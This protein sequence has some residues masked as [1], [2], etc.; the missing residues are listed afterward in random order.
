MRARISSIAREN[1]RKKI[2]PYGSWKSPITSDMVA[3]GNIGLAQIE[4]KDKAIYW[5]EM[6]PSEK[7]RH[8]I[9]KHSNVGGTVDINPP[10]FNART[11]VHEYGGGSYKIV[12]NEV[13]FINFADQII[14]RMK[15]GENPN[16]I[17]FETALR[18]ADFEFD[19][20]R[21]RL[22]CIREDHREKGKE[23]TNTV[24]SM[25]LEG[26]KV[27]TLTQ[28]NDFYSSPR[29]SPN[30]KYLAFL[31]WNHP[32]MPWDK[33]EL[34]I[35][36]L[37]QD[38]SIA[39]QNR[40]NNNSTESIVQPVW[41]PDNILYFVSDRNNWWNI[42]CWKDDKVR[43]I[44]PKEA[45]FA[46][47]PWIFAQSN[48]DFW[49]ENKIICSF[50][51]KGRWHIARLDTET[52][53]LEV[54]ETPYTYI[55]SLRTEDDYAVFIGGSP[56]VAN[57]IVKMNLKTRETEVL[58]NSN[59]ITIDSDYLSP[60]QPIEF[61]TEKGLTAYAI[62]YKPKNKRY[63][64][65]LGTLPP[66]LVS[67][68]GGPTAAASKTFSLKIQF[69]TSRGFAVIEANYGGSTGYG[70]EY[71][72]RLHGQWGVVDVDDSVN[73]AKYLVELGEV[74]EEKLAI[75][76]GSAGGYTTLNSLT[77]RDI[78]KTGASYFGISDLET[79]VKDTHKFE[80]RYLEW[81][82]GC[83]PEKK[84]VY[85]QRS[86]I[87]FLE[88]LDAPMIVFQGLDDKIVPPNQAEL[89]VESLRKKGR[90]IVYL[91]FKDEQHGFR[92]AKN[93]KRSLE[94]ELFFYSRIFGFTP[95]NY[96]EPVK[97]ENFK[98]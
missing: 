8:V 27:K 38:G 73:A 35:G 66:L 51:Q 40:L 77:F 81:L 80:S 28:G 19:R 41:S 30:G 83:Y 85:R 9:V 42:Y 72:E 23:A 49:S 5:C 43:T 63:T 78:F 69:W 86:A 22:I 76:G 16:P 55:S 31:T 60:P 48:Y 11:R 94:T 65:P 58:K 12:K 13:F 25:N 7:G 61:P 36:K 56:Q 14:Y 18:H 91:P 92:Q 32:N 54:L 15:H 52:G 57:S 82:V 74:D 68:H 4:L 20:F 29:I 45:E 34:W 47:P 26:K 17:T 87:N 98:S 90:P 39:K 67:V 2:A 95:A 33:N 21:E 46:E 70:R 75:R 10:P 84:D 64:A 3:S 50:N 1:M 37:N 88:K 53:Q 24:V 97:I 93:I 89:I 44:C 96:I 62:Y 59:K 79:F 71:R 6:R